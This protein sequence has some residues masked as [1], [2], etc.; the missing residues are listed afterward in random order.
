[1]PRRKIMLI[2]LLMLFSVLLP[3]LITVKAESTVTVDVTSYFDSDNQVTSHVSSQTFGD[4]VSFSSNL[5]TEAGYTFFCWIYNGVVRTDLPQDYAFTVTSNTDLVGI[6]RPT[7]KYAAV[8]IDANGHLIAVQYVLPGGN[9]SDI[10]SGSLPSKPGY[11]IAS[12]KWDQSL[13]EI[14]GNTIFTLQ[15]AK[16]VS[17]TY[18]LS[19]TNGSGSGTYGYNAYATLIAYAPASGMY[20]S[21]WQIGDKVV[22]TASTYT[23][24]V[25]ANA[26]LE[27]VYSDSVQTSYP[28]VSLGNDLGLRDGYYTYLG[29][30]EIP[31]GY[32]YVE[33]G[34]I[35]AS[36][37]DIIDLNSASIT[38][39]QGSKYNTNTNEFLISVPDT[40]VGSVR[41]YL[42]VKDFDGN[43]MTFYDE[44]IVTAP[45]YTYASDLFFSYY[46]EGS[47]YNK[48]LAIFNGTGSAVDL[49]AYTVSLYSNGASSASSTLSMTGTLNHGDVY[50]IAYSSANA[51][52]LAMADVTSAVA[53]FNGDDALE[54]LKASVVVD[55]IGQKGYDPGTAWSN[56][57]VSTL[58][59]SLIR[60]SSVT[61]GRADS[62]AVF[63][64]SLE[65]TGY[66]IDYITG[67][68]SHTMDN[69]G[70]AG[71]SGTP[72]V[73]SIEAHL[74]D[75]TYTVGDSINL[76]GA[77]LRVFY[78]DGS[79]ETK[80]LTGDLISGFSTSTAGT[81]SLTVT[82]QSKTDALVF[83]V[84]EPVGAATLLIHEVYGGGGNTGATYT[85]DYVVLYNN[86]TNPIDLSGYSLQYG[87]A[88]G[89]TYSKL[90]LS[91]TIGA[92]GY[93]LISLASSG[94]V[95][96]ALPVTPDLSGSLQLSATAG[97]L[98][99]VVNGDL[100]ASI[101]D[102]DIVDFV[103]YGSTANE[104]ETA[105]TANLSSSLSAKR[106]SAVDTDDNA[107]DFTVGTPNLGYLSTG[108]GTLED[109][110]Y[111]GYS[112][113]YASIEDS[114]DVITD[115][116][117]LLRSTIA[118]VSYGDAR[119]VYTVYD[120]DSQVVLYDVPTSASY[121]LVPAT[122]LDG[123]GDGG[124][125]TTDTYSITLNR[126]HVWACSD[127]RIM[128]TNSDRSLD[129]YVGF[130]L[131]DGSFDYRPDNT[132]SGHYSDLQNLWNALASPNITHS[133]H[134]FGEENGASVDPYLLNDIFYPGDEYKG[135]IARILFYMTLMYPYLTLVDQGSADAVEGTIYYG[136]LDI[137][138]EWNAEDPVSP[139]ELQR[140]QTIF[141]Q[142]GNRNPF[143]DFYTQD[144]AEMLF[145]S[146]DPEVA[147]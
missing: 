76:S 9:A 109:L 8:F 123:W 42:I 135:D 122:G 38:R 81:F 100:I 115:M 48:A 93:Y 134:F 56:N 145:A 70:P 24:T 131:N 141:L 52:I 73:A 11:E 108:G 14:A 107:T 23:F 2:V 45:T 66:A 25:L 59:S 58:D 147:D 97:K 99:L 98:A 103:G 18:T 79:A 129:T 26:T 146:G 54:L 46:V 1:M 20:F 91:G 144:F 80:A 61:G 101:S 16:T 90:D 69:M 31:A 83:T 118:Y 95:G 60:K 116:A 34:L 111:S 112:D 140:T 63:D 138:L 121:Q 13:S 89:T 10:D 113:F 64:P 133:D 128:P 137:L 102:T 21:H 139:Y 78:V 82:Y 87:A 3:N 41:G 86:T 68:D 72:A 126:E 125:I 104:Y 84:S 65:W 15:Y 39:Y 114:T 50:V 36:S 132:D 43:L 30:F 130:I 44:L 75:S 62:T 33:H 136:F 49:S 12:T 47:S 67:L 40:S 120:N 32:E 106:S 119:Y 96:S 92:K 71:G 28:F 29:H 77:Y 117:D 53:N 142:Q 105:P 4:S 110:D 127:M 35:T 7:D 51:S 22:S 19:V 57:G 55:S 17:T 6:F 94:S 124:V 74:G 143:V 27:A 5:A 88:T 85:N 37:T